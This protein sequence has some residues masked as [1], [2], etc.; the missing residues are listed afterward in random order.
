M[1]LILAGNVYMFSYVVGELTTRSLLVAE[2]FSYV[3]L[4]LFDVYSPNDLNSHE[5]SLLSPLRLSI[6]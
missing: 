4:P 1:H 5:A 2:E 6:R 3:G